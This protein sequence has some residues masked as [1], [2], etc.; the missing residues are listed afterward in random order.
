VDWTDLVPGV[1]E[2]RIGRAV[3]L[4]PWVSAREKGVLF[5]SFETEWFKL[6][7]HCDLHAFARRYALV[8]APSTCPHN[9]VGY[10]FPAAFPSTVFTLICH[11]E[12]VDV[13][14]RVAPNYAVVPLYA[15]SWVHPDLFRPLPRAQ[16]DID[17]VMVANF[18]KFKRHHAL[19][20]ALRRMPS[21]L[22]VH[23][24][25]QPQDGRTADTIRAAARSY[26][27][28]G[29]FTLAS[30]AP[31]AA[32]AEALCRAR[33]SVI[34]SRREGSCVAVAESLFAGTPAAVLE[35]AA[36]G[37]RAFIN[38]K[39]GRLLK[40]ADLAGQ[41]TAFIDESDGYAPREWAQEYI[42]CFKSSA[43]LNDVVRRHMFAQGED[44]TCDLAPLCWRLDP[45]LARAED[46]P[47]MEAAYADIRER[48]NLEIGSG[49]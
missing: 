37:S 23:L 31:Y 34:L 9:L 42:S 1:A 2:R 16:R 15:S 24:I 32:V 22:R 30:E 12:E 29:R 19:F 33:A 39:T 35:N 17:L 45:C 26:G 13:L 28:E 36:V 46:R 27:V 11:A 48:F 5:V 7:C 49:R 21:S 4:K 14:P 20:K 40:D 25:G 6:L 41:L 47:R 38:P 43:V 18:A 3:V 8:V 44:W 10:V